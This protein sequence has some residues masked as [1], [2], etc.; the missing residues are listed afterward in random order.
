MHGWRCSYQQSRNTEHIQRLDPNFKK[1]QIKQS[2]WTNDG[3]NFKAPA[4]ICGIK[5]F[6]SAGLSTH[7]ANSL[8]SHTHVYISSAYEPKEQD[9]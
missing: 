3:T 9:S 2:S 5:P 1:K 8:N 4:L 6:A 7:F